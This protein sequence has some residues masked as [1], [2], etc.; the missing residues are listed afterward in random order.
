[1]GAVIS[2]TDLGCNLTCEEITF[3]W[4][5]EWFDVPDNE[6]MFDVML[7]AAILCKERDVSKEDFYQW[8]V[9]HGDL[10]TVPNREKDLRRWLRHLAGDPDHRI[11]KMSPNISGHYTGVRM[12]VDTGLDW[13][14]QRLER[15]G[16]NIDHRRV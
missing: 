13:W 8:A 5:W 15:I 2:R 9:A 10:F 14:Q 16:I 11:H 4:L 1:M 12:P 3:D 6:W 7:G